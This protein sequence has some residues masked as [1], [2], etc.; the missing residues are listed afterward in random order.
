MRNLLSFL[1]AT[2]T[3]IQSSPVP[4]KLSDSYGKAAFLATMA[5][6]RDTSEIGS[7]ES[8]AAIDAADSEAKSDAELRMTKLLRHIAADKAINN[9][10][11]K[12]VIDGYKAK[13]ILAI[14][15]KRSAIEEEMRNDPRL[16]AA[17]NREAACFAPLEDALRAREARFPSACDSLLEKK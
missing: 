5:I 16:K 13:L 7:R 3:L 12:T 11:A 9:L 6:E 14:P 8:R 4:E 15:A 10:S 17:G 1:F 2:C